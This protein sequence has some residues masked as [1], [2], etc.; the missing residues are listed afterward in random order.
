MTGEHVW[1]AWMGRLFN[2]NDYRV[3]TLDSKGVYHQSVARS[4]NLKAH[5]VC[6]DC[7]SGW[8]SDLEEQEAKPTMREMILHAAPISLLP[9]GIAAITA[10]TFKCAVVADHE[11][12]SRGKPFFPHHIRLR[13]SR[14]L[15]IPV[16][17]QIWISALHRAQGLGGRFTAHYMK[18]HDG[19]YKG[20]QLYSFTY[21]IGALVLQ[22]TASR[23]MSI[24]KRPNFTP[25]LTQ[26]SRWDC[27]SVPLWPND[28]APVSFPPEK[29]LGTDT[30]KIFAERWSRISQV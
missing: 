16:G 24:A 3:T 13:F 28:G 10:F 14:T 25:R 21:L 20:F 26:N 5:V 7:N 4:L 2:A 23:W 17:V 11:R 1:S 27:V 6:K 19:R 22:L 18:I 12:P 9:S 29:Y 8:M 15:E 30:I